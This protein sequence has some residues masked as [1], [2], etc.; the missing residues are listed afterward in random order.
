MKKSLPW[1][2]RND[3]GAEACIHALGKRGVWTL[4]LGEEMPAWE[5]RGENE[6]KKEKEKNETTKDII[7]ISLSSSM[8]RGC[9]NE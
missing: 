8:K 4:E 7:V 1:R 6:T 9:F 2:R 3:M 5:G